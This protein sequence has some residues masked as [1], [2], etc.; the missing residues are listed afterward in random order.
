VLARRGA[1]VDAVLLA[2]SEPPAVKTSTVFSD[3]SLPAGGRFYPSRWLSARLRAQVH[4]R[5]A[6]K[7]I[8]I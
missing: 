7:V 2:M 8:A 3:D 1:L 5:V 6:P 4:C